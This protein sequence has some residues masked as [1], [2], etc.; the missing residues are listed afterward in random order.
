M[1]A[2]FQTSSVV[3]P[4][5]VSPRQSLSLNGRISE[6]KSDFRSGMQIAMKTV[7]VF[8]AQV[9]FNAPDGE[10]HLGQPPVV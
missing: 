5:F 9:A 10:I 2:E 6:T 7:G 3:V 4:G 8:F 1:R